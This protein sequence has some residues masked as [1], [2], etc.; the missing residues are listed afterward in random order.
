MKGQVTGT[1]VPAH[2]VVELHVR[3]PLHDPAL[4]VTS[5]HPEDEYVVAVWLIEHEVAVT[6]TGVPA[7]KTMLRNQSC[8]GLP[9]DLPL[10]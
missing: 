7:G 3:P 1:G 5:A 6:L 2:P 4:G 8:S 9:L 10:H